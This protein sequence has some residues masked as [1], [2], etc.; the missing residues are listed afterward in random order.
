LKESGWWGAAEIKPPPIESEI[1]PKSTRSVKLLKLVE[2]PTPKVEGLRTRRNKT[3]IQA[4]I[5]LKANR[6][7]TQV[8]DKDMHS[9]TTCKILETDISDKQ[10]AYP[11][12]FKSIVPC[13]DLA[14]HVRRNNLWEL[15]SLSWGT[16]RELNH[17]C[18]P[19]VSHRDYFAWRK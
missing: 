10:H 1:K 3:S 7:T 17:S 13:V 14:V 18:G 8:N 19:G 5:E 11:W 4:A 16:A 15:S 9:Q 6:S 2:S 12:F